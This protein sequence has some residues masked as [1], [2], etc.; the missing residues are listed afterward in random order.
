[1]PPILVPRHSR[2]PE[3]TETKEE[4]PTRGNDIHSPENKTIPDDEQSTYI[5]IY[6]FD[7][8]FPIM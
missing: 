6:N 7:K 5:F 8:I 1:M 3:A 2:V 4:P